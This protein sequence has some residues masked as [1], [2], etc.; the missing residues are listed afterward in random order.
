MF[1]GFVHRSAQI[2]GAEIVANSQIDLDIRWTLDGTQTIVQ[3]LQGE[4][5]ST[6]VSLA[7]ILGK[8]HDL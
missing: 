6:L 1:A 3:S 2:L 7:I 5:V 8:G 4:Q